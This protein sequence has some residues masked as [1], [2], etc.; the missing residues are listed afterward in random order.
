MHCLRSAL[1]EFSGQLDAED[2]QLL[3]EGLRSL[4]LGLRDSHHAR[5]LLP[6]LAE[7]ILARPRLVNFSECSLREGREKVAGGGCGCSAGKA[8]SCQL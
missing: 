5:H 1:E 8:P 4:C 3:P 7:V 2:L 6:A